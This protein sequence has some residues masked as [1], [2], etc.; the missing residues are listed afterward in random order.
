MSSTALAQ[1]V[2]LCYLRAMKTLAEII[3][4]ATFRDILADRLS[5]IV[6]DDSEPQP[7]RDQAAHVLAE[8]RQIESAPALDIISG[9]SRYH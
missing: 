1:S 2:S 6:C 5:R 4:S 9:L 3:S 8:L 7:V